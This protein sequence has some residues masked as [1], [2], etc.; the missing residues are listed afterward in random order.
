MN[1]RTRRLFRALVAASIIAALPLAGGAWLRPTPGPGPAVPTIGNTPA[2]LL[3][4]E[5]PADPVSET[6]V[7][8]TSTVATVPVFPEPRR[9]VDVGEWFGC[10]PPRRT[11]ICVEPGLTPEQQV[12]E[13]V[14]ESA[15]A[16][17]DWRPLVE[18]FFAAADVD[19]ALR[20]VACES[21]GDRWAKNPT[22][23]ASGLFQHLRSLWG[24]RARSAG[25]A[26]TSVF[27]PVANVAVAAWLVYDGGGW[28]HWNPSRGC[29]G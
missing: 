24:P 3:L 8:Q 9:S 4:S 22:S 16:V 28:S 10:R 18:H 15:T 29:W 12:R 23:T 27:D 5:F 21:R 7:R 26:D 1:H 11:T 17:E 6:V 19:R 14:P 13:L 2:T 25:Y 20:I